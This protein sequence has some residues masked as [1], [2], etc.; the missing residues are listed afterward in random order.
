MLYKDIVNR[1]IVN[2][3]NCEDEPIHIPGSI[4]SHGFLIAIDEIKNNITFCSENIIEFIGATY[5]QVLGK[6]ISAVFDEFFIHEL[7]QFKDDLN[8]QV[9]VFNF[10]LKT[11]LFSISFHV[12]NN[13]L[14]IEGEPVDAQFDQ[15]NDL[16]NSS[17]KLLSYIE[18]S[19]TLNEL[20]KAVSETIKQITEYDRVMI[21]RF[22]KD[23]NGEVIAESKEEHLESFLGLH[24]PHTDIPA[25]ARELYIKNQLRIIGDVFYKPIPIYTI[26]SATSENLDLSLAVLRSV[27]PIHIQY[28]QNMGVGA[29]LTISLL[30]KDRLWGLITCHHYSAKYLSQEIRTTAKLHG[31]FITSQIDVRVL[32]EEYEIAQK[33]L[34]EVEKITTTNLN[35]DRNS[36]DDIFN[37][38]SI[39]KLCNSIGASALI[40]GKIYKYG[41]TPNDEDIKRLS[42]FLNEFTAQ[43]SL[44]T[45]SLIKTTSNLNFISNTFPGINYY[46]LKS[47]ADCIIWYRTETI[48]D[49]KWA[50]DPTKTIE[51]DKNGLSPRKSFEQFTE[52]VKGYSRE[53]L[54][55]ELSASFNFY[56]F[57][58][59]H[60]R[61]INLNEEKEKQKRL[62]E[63]LKETNSELENI[64]WIST[65]DLQE[66]LRKIRIMASM[67]LDNE[68]KTLPEF[69]QNKIFKMQ[70]SAERMQTLISDIL[71][72]TKTQDQHT[73]L[74][75]VNLNSLFNELKEEL[76]DHLFDK[77]AELIVNDLPTINGI[78][79]LLK[80][81]FSN[82][83]YNA[84]KF[85]DTERLPI[86]KIS[87]ETEYLDG[88]AIG[89]AGTYFKISVKDNGIGFENE[90]KDKIFKIFSRLH[91]KNDYSGSGIGL[92]LCMKIIM[93][94]GGTINADG[95]LG[96]GATF[97][98]YFPQHKVDF[99]N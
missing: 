48:K 30:H 82:I 37:N 57:F 36:I 64:N 6:H 98:I 58:L 55:S 83:I 14:I 53:W 3:K 8:E 45:N 78:P 19:Y 85:S 79:F 86:I 1:N 88:N 95:E 29:T 23:Y 24:Y 76:N 68:V 66:P 59:N 46:S 54:Q 73:T 92:A 13:Q 28:L 32:N 99:L 94:H 56:N 77:Q 18:D 62:S 39:I 20:A 35:I 43:E 25:Q 52:K 38:P 33:A 17:K 80:Q 90:Y 31:H 7:N 97:N 15:R 5:E 67:I 75:S 10:N 87:A 47:N 65:H 2:L 61:T 27:S 44:N 91:N 60:L 16:Y 96:K 42:E 81:L 93:K 63:I 71:K 69:V 50:G 49:I 84:L 11:G 26:D 89:G 9:K 74:E 41:N 22:D 4:Q 40:D 12:S 51:K 21:Y 70:S 34:G 72:Y